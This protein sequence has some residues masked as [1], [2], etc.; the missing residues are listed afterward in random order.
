MKQKLLFYGAEVVDEL[1]NLVSHI[2]VDR[3]QPES[4]KRFFEQT[5]EGKR[6]K[7]I[8]PSEWVDSSIEEGYALGED[9]FFGMLAH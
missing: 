2:V 6:R 5:Q 1:T 4:W 8:V 7:R 3:N 9:T